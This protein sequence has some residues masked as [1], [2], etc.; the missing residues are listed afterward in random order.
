M[1]ST[2]KHVFGPALIQIQPYGGS[3]TDL[4]YSTE[5]VDITMP[6]A[7]QPIFSDSRG[8]DTPIDV[9]QTGFKIATIEFDMVQWDNT[10]FNTASAGFTG[11]TA[12]VFTSCG[13]LL[14]QGN[15]MIRLLIK[16]SGG[17]S[18]W[19]FPAAYLVELNVNLNTK[20]QRCRM[21]WEAIPNDSGYLISSTAT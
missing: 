18:A 16:G 4:G 2:N 19:N 10:A 1:A 21:K 13:N 3:L 6:I 8:P 11:G 12:G 9:V 14:L 7:F 5:G 15:K 20:I 17:E